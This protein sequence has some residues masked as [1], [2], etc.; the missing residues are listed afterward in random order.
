M[1]HILIT[2]ANSYVGES[3]KKWAESKYSDEFKIDTVD[4]RDDNWRGKSFHGYD[5]IFHV[6]GIVH[7]KEKPEMQS[8]YKVVNTELPME[9]AKKSMAEG[10]KQFIFMSSMSVYGK[11]AGRIKKSDIPVP[12]SYYGRSKLQAEKM[13]NQLS[14]DNFKVAI[15][16]PPMVYGEG[17]KGN[18]QLLKKFVL[19]SPVFPNWKN[20]RSMIHIDVLSEFIIGLIR[21]GVGGVYLPQNKEF[22]CTAELAGKLAGE[23]HK[24][25]KFTG[26]FNWCIKLGLLFHIPLIEK[27]FGTLIYEE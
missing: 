10:V 26:L 18:Y 15:L 9:V 13:L 25:I 20:E 16:R 11:N 6:A 4:M 12:K 27:V 24:K 5:V 22:V 21:D 8:L 1:K 23:Y 19:R 2:G 7:K 14:G 17:C 3:F